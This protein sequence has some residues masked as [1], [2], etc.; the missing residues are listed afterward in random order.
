MMAAADPAAAAV[1][2]STCE[3]ANPLEKQIK[4][5]SLYEEER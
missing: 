4:T 1:K 3:I 5:F 2:R